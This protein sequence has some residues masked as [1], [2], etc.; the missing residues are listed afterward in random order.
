MRKL[1]CIW[2]MISLVGMLQNIWLKITIKLR[3]RAITIKNHKDLND[4]LYHENREKK[5]TY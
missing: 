4:L 1:V 2:I 3:T 5:A